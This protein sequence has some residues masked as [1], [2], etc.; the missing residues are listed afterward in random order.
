MSTG[1]RHEVRRQ[2]ALVAAVGWQAADDHLHLALGRSC[3]ERVAARISRGKLD[4]VI[5]LRAPE[6]APTLAVDE[7]LVEQLGDLARRLHSR[8]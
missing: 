3:R 8:F 5:R 4:L 1:M 6:A 2:L 7:A